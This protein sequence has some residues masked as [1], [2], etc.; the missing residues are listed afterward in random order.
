MIYMHQPEIRHQIRRARA[1]EFWLRQGLLDRTP[2]EER[3]LQ[4]LRSTIAHAIGSETYMRTLERHI[5]CIQRPMNAASSATSSGFPQK[6]DV[7]LFCC[8]IVSSN[9]LSVQ[10]R[11]R[12]R[13]DDRTCPKV[14][15]N[16]GARC[17]LESGNAKRKRERILWLAYR[18]RAG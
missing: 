2:M 4:L 1:V 8:G 16:V 3:A 17:Y 7:H 11:P 12:C 14:I 9:S 10:L 5:E 18:S 13:I 6:N 15:L